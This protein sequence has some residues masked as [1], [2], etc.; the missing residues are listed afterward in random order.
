MRRGGQQQPRRELQ[1]GY[2]ARGQ[3]EEEEKGESHFGP[4]VFMARS[5]GERLGTDVFLLDGGGH[6]P[7][8]GWISATVG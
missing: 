2:L 8:G 1:Q 3:E 5:F 6:L 4:M 7:H